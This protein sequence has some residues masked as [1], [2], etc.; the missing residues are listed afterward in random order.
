MVQYHGRES[1]MDKERNADVSRN[2]SLWNIIYLFIKSE[3]RWEKKN[4]INKRHNRQSDNTKNE[5]SFGFII[6]IR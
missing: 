3:K 1:E 6:Y 2:P 5:E 4:R